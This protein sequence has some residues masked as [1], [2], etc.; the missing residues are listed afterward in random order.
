MRKLIVMFTVLVLQFTSCGIENSSLFVD[1]T[2]VEQNLERYR[3][4]FGA[5]KFIIQTGEEITDSI[6]TTILRVTFQN[7]SINLNDT[8]ISNQS[9]NIAKLLKYNLQRNRKFDR[10]GVMYKLDPVFEIELE[11]SNKSEYIISELYNDFF[12]DEL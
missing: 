4:A 12:S 8:T 6:S 2:E 5:E 9:Q 7:V 3:G 1:D 11:N 10:F